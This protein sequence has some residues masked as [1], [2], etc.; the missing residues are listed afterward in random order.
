MDQVYKL[1][2]RRYRGGTAVLK[3]A[4]LRR[5]VHRSKQGSQT[6]KI[7]FSPNLDKALTFRNDKAL[8]AT[9]N[10][11]VRANR[12]YRKMQKSIYRVRTDRAIDQRIALDLQRERQAQGRLD[13]LSTLHLQR[14]SHR[15]ISH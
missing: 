4:Q 14:T 2:D 8:P 13:T 9:S 7:L 12:R 1:F 10:A 15:S 3:L 11:V 6:L 5:Q